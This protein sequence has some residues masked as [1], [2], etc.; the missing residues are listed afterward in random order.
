MAHATAYKRRSRPRIGL[1]HAVPARRSK[2]RSGE[3]RARHCETRTRTGIGSCHGRARSRERA[4]SPTVVVGACDLETLRRRSDSSI[5]RKFIRWSRQTWC[6]PSRR[7]G[8]F[9]RSCRTAFQPLRPGRRLRLR[10]GHNVWQIRGHTFRVTCATRSPEQTWV[11]ARG[12]R[13]IK[14]D[15]KESR[16]LL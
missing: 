10:L 9:R 11:G 7:S 6:A 2:E 5:Q 12:R 15:S 16:P 1:A 8:C 13:A 4:R 3:V 14:R